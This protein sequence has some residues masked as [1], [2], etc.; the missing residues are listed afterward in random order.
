MITDNNNYIEERL[1]DS[2][3]PS[4]INKCNF[5]SCW[6]RNKKNVVFNNC[7]IDLTVLDSPAT[8]NYCNI[9]YNEDTELP[10]GCILYMSNYVEKQEEEP[11]QSGG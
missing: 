1:K 9:Y 7:N 11:E 6:I 5:I 3:L 8:F 10:E 4:E 2:E